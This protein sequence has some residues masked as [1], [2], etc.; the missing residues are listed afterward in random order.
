MKKKLVSFLPL[1]VYTSLFIYVFVRATFLSFTH[2]ESLSYAL[3]KV[4]S[5]IG[6]KANHHWLNTWLMSVCSSLFGD[7]EIALRLP[8]VLAFIP[9]AFYGHRLISLPG[10]KYFLLLVIPLL[11]FNPFV[12]DYFSLAR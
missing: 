2:D 3:I 1:I 12:M 11:F 6:D 10:K 5:A 4:D 7:K 8:N 9:Y